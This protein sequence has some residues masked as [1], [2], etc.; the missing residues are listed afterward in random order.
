MAWIKVETTTPDKPEIRQV[1]RACKVTPDRAFTGFF[2][3]WAYFDSITETGNI[4][5]LRPEDCDDQAHVP[6]IGQAFAD[7]FIR[8][9]VEIGRALGQLQRKRLPQEIFLRAEPL[10]FAPPAGAP[11]LAAVVPGAHAADQ[12][13]AVGFDPDFAGSCFA[14]M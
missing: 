5:H 11:A 1:A 7:V 2:R 10:R 9:A 8:D 4:P 6:G 3:L 13:P 14:L 12:L